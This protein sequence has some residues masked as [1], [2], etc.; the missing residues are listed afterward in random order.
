MRTL[1]KLI[2]SK[3]MWL[4]TLLVIGLAMT[5]AVRAVDGLGLFELDGNATQQS[6]DDWATLSGG[7]SAVAFTGI[8]AD[9]APL[10]IFTGGGSKD[11]RDVSEWRHKDGSVP[12]KDN[13]TNAYAAAYINQ[14]NTGPHQAG[15]LIITF[16]LDRFANN[17]DAQAGFWFF[18]DEVGLAPDGSFIGNHQVGDILV[19]V[20]YPQGAN[21]SPT[22]DVYEWNPGLASDNLHLLLSTSDALCDGLGNK[23]VCAITNADTTDA[24]WPYE[25]KFPDDSSPNDFPFES[26][27]EGGINVSALLGGEVPCFSS[28]LAETRSSRSETAQLKDF[29]LGAFDVC[30]ID[31][32]KQCTAGVSAGG[33]LIDISFGGVVTNTGALAL[34]VTIYDDMGTPNDT[35]DDVK[36]YDD[37]L[38]AGASDNYSGSFQTTDIPSTDRVIATGTRGQA[39]VQATADATCSPALDERIAVT[40]ACTATLNSAGDMVDVSYGGTVSNPGNVKLKDI[41]VVDDNG[42]PLDESDDV[43]LI[44]GLSLAPGDSKDFSGSYSTTD[45]TPTDVVT[46]SGVSVLTS[47]PV[48]DSA[49]ASCAPDINPVIDVTKSCTAS[50]NSAGDSV[51]VSFSGSVSNDGNEALKNITVVD[52]NGTPGDLSDDVTVLTIAKL[53]AGASQNFSGS[54]TTTNASSTDIVVANGTGVLSASAVSDNATATCAPDLNPSIMVSKSCTAQINSAGDIVDVSFQG[55]V[56]NNGNEALKNVTVKDDNGT[57]GD[58]SDD[59]VVANI[60]KLDAGASQNFSGS[61]TTTN[62][63]STDIV[64]A[65]GTGVI[66]ASAVSDNASATCAPDLNPSLMVSKA[67]TAQL[68]SAGDI[69]DV[70]F[71]G[72]V[73]NNGNEALKNVTVKDDSGT[74]GDLSDDVVVLSIAKLNAGASQNFS[75]SFTTTDASSTDI[76]VAKGTGVISASAVSDNAS[77]TCAPDL[78]PSIMVSKVCTAQI[79]SA[80]NAVDVSF[81]G[82]VTNTGNE[83]LKNVI[84]KDDSG[85]PSD[86]SDDVVVLNIAKLDAG[87][88]QNYSGVFSTGDSTSTDIV[89]VKGTGLISAT[90]VSDN[91]SATC[92]ADILPDINVTKECVDPAVNGDPILFSGTVT[93][94]GNVELNDVTVVDDNGT[95]GDTSDD[96]TVLGPITLAP[97]ASDSYSGSYLVL[98]AGPSTDVVTASG[99]DAI[100]S[101]PVE[102]TASATCEVPPPEEEG[103]TPGFWKNNPGRWSYT[104]YDPSDLLS[105]V[106]DFTGAPNK[107]YSLSSDTL[108]EALNYGGGTGPDGAAQVLLRAAVAAVLNAN[109]GKVA[110]PLP[111]SYVISEVSSAL[112][113]GSRETMLVLANK[114]DKANN[115]VLID[116][117]DTESCPLTADESGKEF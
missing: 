59:V 5:A 32:T 86:L 107:V 82:T 84:V 15:D 99:A 47:T 73:T 2:K 67:C 91:A 39:T 10:S 52:D 9:P 88:S 4:S 94:V 17:G 102:A 13:I 65:N 48:E 83:A 81:Q 61:F 7:G 25:A 44:S 114:L 43:T 66:S 31:V 36:V 45:I 93:N 11:V 37:T 18:Q 51:L 56:T 76:V 20:E 71:Q 60:A 54:F 53:D 34:D 28:F 41:T 92:A 64:V 26:F 62:A 106:F 19:L 1:R 78:N 77:A 74:P 46:A 57:P 35:S 50:I 33:D 8:I 89:V 72:T 12:D 90:A 49:E 40:K 80:G 100:D 22:I 109:H 79:N 75:G 85:T 23:E 3:L 112:Q 69:V 115:G 113:S 105:S 101:T 70:N 21:A 38:A 14:L 58:L 27:F 29:V 6:Y 110:Y 108:M 16:G 63:S 97:G 42:T 24:P 111:E 55:T 95:P 116:N 104:D 87:A 98:V 103:C 96:Q 68:N 30:S 117:G